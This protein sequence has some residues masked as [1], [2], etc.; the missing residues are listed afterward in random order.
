METHVMWRCA[1]RIDPE[2]LLRLPP[3]SLN[4][5]Y[6]EH[7]EAVEKERCVTHA[8]LHHWSWTGSRGLQKC[9]SPQASLL[10]QRRERSFRPLSRTVNHCSYVPHKE[11]ISNSSSSESKNRSNLSESE[12]SAKGAGV[13]LRASTLT[14]WEGWLSTSSNIGKP[15]LLQESLLMRIHQSSNSSSVLQKKPAAMDGSSSQMCMRQGGCWQWY[16]SSGTWPS[17]H[18][19]TAGCVVCGSK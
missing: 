17:S 19:S 3:G 5:G 4:V 18:G 9:S 6:R 15:P 12:K 11:R 1:Y 8:E 14:M 10:I 7:S 16:V 2:L 13:R